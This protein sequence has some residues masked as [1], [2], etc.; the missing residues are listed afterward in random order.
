M[1]RKNLEAHKIPYKI[2][3]GDT[4][5]V[6]CGK[7]K[8]EKGKVLKVMR[9]EDR[10][11]I[12]QVNYIYKHLRKSQNHPKGG[13]VQKESPIAYSN[14]MIICPHCNR[15]TRTNMVFENEGEKSEKRRSCKKCKGLF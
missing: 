2:K 9:K 1:V 12:E 10:V 14:V 8:G 11:I 15:R 5:E 6:I 3:R 13:R 7:N 4:V